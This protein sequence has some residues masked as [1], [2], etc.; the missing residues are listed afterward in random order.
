MVQRASWWY[1]SSWIK[2]A[3]NLASSFWPIW[4][5]NRVLRGWSACNRVAFWLWLAKWWILGGYFKNWKESNMN[6]KRGWTEEAKV[7]KAA[8]RMPGRALIF[9][10]I[11]AKVNMTH[12]LCCF[13]SHPCQLFLQGVPWLWET[14]LLDRQTEC[15]G[16]AEHWRTKATKSV[17]NKCIKHITNIWKV[18]KQ[19]VR[20]IK[21]VS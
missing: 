7:A 4:N 21:Y 5:E 16:V 15:V 10:W 17:K 3:P 13:S 14:S 2:P 19:K 9:Q 1:R 18:W 8:R 12:Q 11:L 20:L 6:M